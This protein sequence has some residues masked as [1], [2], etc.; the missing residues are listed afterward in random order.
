MMALPA[1]G[2]IS[3]SDIN[4]ELSKSSTAQG[5]LNDTD[6]RTLAG[7]TGPNTTISYSDFYGKSSASVLITNQSAVNNSLE[8]EGGTATATYRLRNDG[9]AL[10]TNNFGVLTVISGEWLVSGTVS[11]FE[12]YATWSG[13]GGTVGGTTDSWI[14]L[15]T[16]RDWTLTV[17]SDVIVRTLDIQIRL[18]STLVVLDTATISF[19]VNCA[20]L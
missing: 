18:A 14:S 9:V 2:P 4:L 15:D 7:I 11:Q 19:E 5:S 13:T 16:T 12:V 6:W 1:S 20:P 3:A 10:A 17:T 8:G